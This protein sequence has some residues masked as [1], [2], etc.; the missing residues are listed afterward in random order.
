MELL[1]ALTIVSLLAAIAIPAYSR[2]R[3]QAMV[4]RCCI[5]VRN[6]E[7]AIAAYQA[8][9]D[10][11]PDVLTQAQPFLPL[12]PWG[13]PYQ[14]LRI[15]GGTVK[16]KGKLRR[17]KNLNPLNADFDLYSMGPDGK[18]QT[19]LN[20]KFARDDIVRANS[21]TYVGVATGY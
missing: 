15:D 3:E 14:Y 10:A 13:N 18:T 19:Q 8:E 12:D 21:G 1:T 5:E 4:Q 7:K 6:L 2:Y 9:N 20:A 11:L 17:D 16:G